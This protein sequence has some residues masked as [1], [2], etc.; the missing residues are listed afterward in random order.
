MSSSAARYTPTA[1]DMNTALWRAV[2]AADY[3]DVRWALEGNGRHHLTCKDQKGPPFYSRVPNIRKEKVHYIVDYAS[4][5]GWTAA[6]VAARDG[7]VK[8]LKL[9]EKHGWDMRK[10]NK[11]KQTPQEVGKAHG[12]TIHFNFKYAKKKTTM[13]LNSP[14]SPDLKPLN[15]VGIDTRLSPTNSFPSNASP[16]RKKTSPL[17]KKGSPQKKKALPRSMD[18]REY[19]KSKVQ[20]TKRHI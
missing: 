13:R 11:E 3:E 9:L 12:H 16:K 19:Q 6:H 7:N 14:R 5:T 18:E 20:N 1:R 4:S 8:I 10:L 15:F 17:K 2:W